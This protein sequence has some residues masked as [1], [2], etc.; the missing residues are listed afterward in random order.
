MGACLPRPQ[1]IPTKG[2]WWHRGQGEGPQQGA[3][4]PLVRWAAQG[5]G[6]TPPSKWVPLLG[7]GW[8]AKSGPS[9]PH[10]KA[11]RKGK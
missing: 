3:P 4:S 10:G 1:R 11:T 5:L 2:N 9:L 6:A 7:Q 8:R